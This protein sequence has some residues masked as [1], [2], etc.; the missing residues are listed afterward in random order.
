M[1]AQGRQDVIN[2]S[3]ENIG[4]LTRGPRGSSDSVYRILAHARCQRQYGETI[5]PKNLSLG[6]KSSSPKFIS[7]RLSF[8]RSGGSFAMMARTSFVRLVGR[9]KGIW[10]CSHASGNVAS[11]WTNRIARYTTTC[12]SQNPAHLRTNQFFI[13][14]ERPSRTERH[15]RDIGQ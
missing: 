9:H 7:I 3:T 2:L 8:S 6:L 11:A 1:V 4:Q 14:I 10:I 12:K 5:P 13:E 15:G